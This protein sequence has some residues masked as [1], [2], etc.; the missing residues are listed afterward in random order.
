LEKLL[1]GQLPYDSELKVLY[2]VL[3]RDVMDSLMAKRPKRPGETFMNIV[4]LPRSLMATADISAPGRQGLFLVGSKAWRT[5]WKDMFKGGKPSRADFD[6]IHKEMEA[7]P[8]YEVA[9]ENGL[10]ITKDSQFLEDREEAFMSSWAEKMPGEKIPGLGLAVKG[11]NKTAGKVV[12][13]SDRAYITYLNKLRFDHFK[14]IY[15]QAQSAGVDVQD[16]KFLSSLTTFINAATGRGGLGKLAFAGQGLNATFFSPQLI[17]SRLKLVNPI[18]YA[19]LHPTV[20]KEALKSLFSFAAITGSIIG[21]AAA[22]GAEI[23]TDRGHSDL[24]KI[25]IGN[26]RMDMS[27]GIVPYIRFIYNEM[28]MGERTTMGGK[29]VKLDGKNFP[30]ESRGSRALHFAR[31]KLSPAASL[32]VDQ[33]FEN[34]KNVIGEEHTLTEDMVSRLH[35]MII[36]DLKEAYD[37]W[38]AKGLAFA[39]PMAVGI[40][41]TTFDTEKPLKKVEK[42][43]ETF[44]TE[45]TSDF[46]AIW[47]SAQ[48]DQ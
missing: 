31:T 37:E 22:A 47:N 14:A 43:T 10:A 40:S 13:M 20:R 27:A 36:G 24:L 19:R 26:T 34:G 7:D 48:D 38:G 5:S 32:I 17:T 44:Q 15:R 25:K 39:V 16:D 42:E 30:F 28:I 11:Y 41:T 8:L 3:P 2:K 45:P 23:N 33:F 35:P 6:R 29:E 18:W 12:E 1:T 4:N 9:D 21:L 46:D